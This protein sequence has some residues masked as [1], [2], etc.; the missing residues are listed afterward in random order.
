MSIAREFINR[1]TLRGGVLL[2]EPSDA[3]AMIERAEQLGVPVLGIDGFRM[4]ET[5]TQ[6]D[7]EH[8][9]DLSSTGHGAWHEAGEFISARADRG[10]MF[11]VVA[12]EDT[13]DLR[14]PQGS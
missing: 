11:E 6:P 12:D 9:I 13:S 10:L 8:S 1:G 3:L 4:T 7:M 2:L 14:Q 5:T